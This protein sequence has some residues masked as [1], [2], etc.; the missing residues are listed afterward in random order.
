MPLD[1]PGHRSPQLVQIIKTNFLPKEK[2]RGEDGEQ[3][4]GFCVW[5]DGVPCACLRSTFDL[6][7]R[8]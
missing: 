6:L 3:Y 2:L 8:Q 4:K 7:V 5:P 1:S